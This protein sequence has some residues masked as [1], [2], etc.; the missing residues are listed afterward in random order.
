VGSKLPP[1]Y[2]PPD[3]TTFDQ[4]STLPPSGQ[5]LYQQSR[6]GLV[7]TAGNADGLYDFAL[8]VSLGTRTASLS[9][10]NLNSS[11]LG[12]SGVSF[13]D[14]AFDFSSYPTGFNIP[15]VFGVTSQVVGSSDSACVNGCDAVGGAV[16][17]NGN[18]RI[19]DSALPVVAITAPVVTGA[20]VLETI[21]TSVVPIP[22]T[23][24]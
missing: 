1:Y 22:Q 15:A 18:G 24:P 13:G 23:Q 4:L 14:E 21:S 5:L 8:Q 11:S 16:L 3:I 19:A 10:S 20:P 9:I 12:L 7:D 6:L 2:L 17:F